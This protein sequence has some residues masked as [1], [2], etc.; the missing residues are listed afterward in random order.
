MD[1]GAHSYHSYRD[2]QQSLR[3]MVNE[4]RAAQ[5][6]DGVI[7]T[8]MP[9]LGQ[10]LIPDLVEALEQ[11]A[12]Q[13]VMRETPLQ[14]LL[15]QRE[16]HWQAQP[17]KINTFGKGTGDGGL[18]ISFAHLFLQEGDTLV[19]VDMPATS[20]LSMRHRDCNGMVP[21]S[22]VF[23]V[24]SD[25]LF[26][27]SKSRFPTMM[28]SAHH[29]QRVMNH[30]KPTQDQLQGINYLLDLTPDVEGDDAACH[31]S[32]LSLSPGLIKWSTF[33]LLLGIS[34]ALIGGH[35]D[36]CA[37]QDDSD[38]SDGFKD[39][40]FVKYKA[41]TRPSVARALS[42]YAAIKKPEDIIN[43]RG[44]QNKKLFEIAPH[45]KTPDYCQVR[46]TNAIIRLMLMIEGKEVPFNSAARLWTMVGVSKI[47]GCP[48]VLR[49]QV[50]RWIMANPYFIEILP[51][52]ALE[53]AFTLEL[54]QIARLAFR[55]L[56][57]EATI[58]AF[59][60]ENGSQSPTKLTVFGRQ[61]GRL[62][63]ELSNIVQHATSALM[64]RLT[65]S[66]DWF[67]Q[68]QTLINWSPPELKILE[69]I[70]SIINLEY[71][72]N[73]GA[74]HQIDQLER[75]LSHA[76]E[77]IVSVCHISQWDPFLERALD[78]MDM[79]RATY[80][81]YH[82]GQANNF[83]K[84][85]EIMESLTLKQKLVCPFIYRDT[86]KRFRDGFIQSDPSFSVQIHDF[87]ITLQTL[88]DSR[89]PV[90]AGFPA[91]NI[92]SFHSEVSARAQTWA[93]FETR[94]PE[95]ED[96]N[97]VTTHHMNLTLTHHEMKY[98][99]L[100]A[101][102]DNDETGGVFAPVL[103]PAKLGPSGPGPAYHTGLSEAPSISEEIAN[104]VS[105]MKLR[106]ST[107]VGSMDAQDS[108]STVFAPDHVIAAG[109]SN[110]S[111][112]FEDDDSEFRA[113]MLV[114]SVNDE[115]STQSTNLTLEEMDFIS[116][117][118]STIAGSSSD[119]F[120]WV[121]DAMSDAS[122]DTITHI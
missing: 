115:S 24:H 55:I 83:V 118:D 93:W 32:D 33:A 11:S 101:G 92:D 71:W 82:D 112:S 74:L 87:E 113:A 70:K 72:G 54:P 120:E 15:Y 13:N 98:L 7:L 40:N 36:V 97:P 108:V 78:D 1:P 67:V 37:C 60:E 81:E 114:A 88:R 22:Q 46:H 39:D 12:Y 102:G 21:T 64:E 90:G 38:N 6:Q 105:E 51:E 57:N 94:G 34:N 28:K 48:E 89:Y 103:P 56:V 61:K 73:E 122:D 42:D 58:E 75:A 18:S 100:W 29:Q 66:H 4:L 110:A 86:Y 53:V 10:E 111:E 119:D 45:L 106:A 5:G 43:F 65:C 91:L 8:M 17:N 99:P 52:E 25:K 16:N 31:L 84:L 68:G 47:F 69:K 63:D 62:G 85:N 44:S 20:Q 96:L 109:S 104:A 50:E 107:V 9:P 76:L 23:R 26:A 30:R 116:E 79:C 14:R 27:L 121:G 77:G 95:A 19:F 80:V 35:D 41:S 3:V 117:T 49:D 2:S 59:G